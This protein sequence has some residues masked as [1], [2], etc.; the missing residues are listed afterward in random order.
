[1]FGIV[2]NGVAVAQLSF[3]G[4]VPDM[5]RVL[6]VAV[7]VGVTDGLVVT[8]IFPT[9]VMLAVM[10]RPKVSFP[11]TSATNRYLLFEFIPVC[12][13]IENVML[14]ASGCGAADA[15]TS[16]PPSYVPFA[17]TS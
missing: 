5:V 4:G 17:F 16:V 15:N 10:V 14:A 8:E 1:M 7:P 6:P 13:E 11:L 3:T 12:P 9:G 2:G